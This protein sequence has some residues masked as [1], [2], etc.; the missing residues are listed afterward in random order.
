MEFRFFTCKLVQ[1]HLKSYSCEPPD[2][3][4]WRPRQVCAEPWLGA[5]GPEGDAGGNAPRWPRGQLEGARKAHRGPAA[6]QL[7]IALGVEDF[8]VAKDSFG[9]KIILPVSL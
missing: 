2:R 3:A 4:R 1:A 5:V 7:D 8:E 6:G 9:F